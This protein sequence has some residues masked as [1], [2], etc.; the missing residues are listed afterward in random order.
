LRFGVT[1]ENASSASDPL[2][3]M[4]ADTRALTKVVAPVSG[5]EPAGSKIAIPERKY[6]T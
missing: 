5:N 6:G 3:A 2:A 1:P 4:L